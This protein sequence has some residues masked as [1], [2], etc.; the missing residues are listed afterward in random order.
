MNSSIE[1]LP[2]PSRS[3]FLNLKIQKCKIIISENFAEH[4]VFSCSGANY[5]V[6]SGLFEKP[7]PLQDMGPDSRPRYEY[8]DKEK[9]IFFF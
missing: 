8:F 2:D 9:I 7:I 6:E 3:S 1:R 4:T 5:E